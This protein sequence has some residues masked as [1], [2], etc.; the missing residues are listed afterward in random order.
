MASQATWKGWLT[1]EALNR[2]EQRFYKLT[3][4][5]MV[6]PVFELA[7]NNPR[8]YG[9][10]LLHL[11]RDD[12]AACGAHTPPLDDSEVGNAIAFILNERDGIPKCK[13]CLKK[14]VTNG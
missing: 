6:T 9:G 11:I 2:A 4:G 8:S 5:D 10:S 14:E 12:R 7:M 1:T 3:G 13:R